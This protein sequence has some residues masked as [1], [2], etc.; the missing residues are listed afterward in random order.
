MY[1][2][3]VDNKKPIKPNYEMNWV[4]M[5]SIVETVVSLDSI[6]TFCWNNMQFH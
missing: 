4:K 3:R 6:I 2:K 5:I 1:R